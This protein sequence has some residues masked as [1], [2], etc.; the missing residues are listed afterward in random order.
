MEKI[1]IY[2]RDWPMNVGRDGQK[3]HVS[4]TMLKPT[5]IYDIRAA[6]AE[7]DTAFQRR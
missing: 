7:P 6:M 2:Q 1:A 5:P 4:G 3:P